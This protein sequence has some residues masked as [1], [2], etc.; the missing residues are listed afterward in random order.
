MAKP[1][2][3][4]KR[5]T[6]RTF[7]IFA[8]VAIIA[9]ISLRSIRQE[10]PQEQAAQY[11]KVGRLAVFMQQR[12]RRELH[13]DGFS[14]NYIPK[15]PDKIL[16]SVQYKATASRNLIST[17]VSSAKEII[18]RKGSE[19]FQLEQIEVDVELKAVD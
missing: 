5:I 8:P 3:R 18:H 19:L 9:V 12:Y 2:P 10:V 15:P 14:F 16:I 6:W 13:E 4:R 17:L 11:E 7:A 1:V